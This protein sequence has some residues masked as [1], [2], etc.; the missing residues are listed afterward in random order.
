MK[1]KKAISTDFLRENFSL[2][3]LSIFNIFFL[4]G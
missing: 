2:T 4:I 3:G 1:I